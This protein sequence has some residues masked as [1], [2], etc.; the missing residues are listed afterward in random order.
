MADYLIHYNKNHNPKNGRF[1]FGDGD[2]DGIRN[3]HKNANK[4]TFNQ[5]MKK[6]LDTYD[7]MAADQRKRTLAA[8]TYKVKRDD[9]RRQ[10]DEIAKSRSLSLLIPPPSRNPNIPSISNPLKVFQIAVASVR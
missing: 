5:K 2:G 9:L 1:D 3:D 7:R 6:S 4:E 8:E 10:Q